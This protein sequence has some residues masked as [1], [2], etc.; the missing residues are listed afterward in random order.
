[1][2]GGVVELAF[3]DNSGLDDFARL[4]ATSYPGADVVLVCFGIDSPDSLDNVHEVWYPEVAYFCPGIPSFLVGC[5]ADLRNDAR[6]IEELRKTGQHPV[7]PNQGEQFRAMIGAQGYFE[8][9]AR[10]NQGIAELFEAATRAALSTK[11]KKSHD[12]K[13]G[14]FASLSFNRHKNRA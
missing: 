10:T 14:I 1:M 3:W 13:K 7:T 11:I 8:C 4:R 2:D 9:S 5:K 12:K 6:T